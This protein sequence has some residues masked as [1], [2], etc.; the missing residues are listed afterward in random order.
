[1]TLRADKVLKANT[2]SVEDS[3]IYFQMHYEARRENI[4]RGLNNVLSVWQHWPVCQVVVNIGFENSTETFVRFIYVIALFIDTSSQLW[5]G[6]I[7]I[8]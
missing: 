5:R 1:M 8:A 6:D 2:D 4:T 7:N 3:F